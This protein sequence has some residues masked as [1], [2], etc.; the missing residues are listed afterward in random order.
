MQNPVVILQIGVFFAVM[1]GGFLLWSLIEHSETG[2]W[3]FIPRK[4]RPQ[5]GDVRRK[6]TFLWLPKTIKGNTRF[7][8]RAEIIQIYSAG[9][10]M[11]GY[12]WNPAGWKNLDWGEFVESVKVENVRIGLF[13]GS[14][15]GDIVPK[16]RDDV[17][18]IFDERRVR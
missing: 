1:V 12:D 16:R 5:P 2:Q 14:P 15:R 6:K 9:G 3:C 17:L 13:G 18:V 8:E 7:W 11:T 10:S 4:F